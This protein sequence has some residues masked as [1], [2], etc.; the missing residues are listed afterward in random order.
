M[1]ASKYQVLGTSVLILDEIDGHKISEEERR[2]FVVRTADV[3]YGTGSSRVVFLN[4][5]GQMMEELATQGEEGPGLSTLNTIMSNKGISEAFVVRTF[6]ATGM[7]MP[8]SASALFSLG[9]YFYRLNSKKECWIVSGIET[10]RPNIHYVYRESSSAY[11]N[12]NLGLPKPLEDGF[13]GPFLSILTEPA[14]SSENIHSLRVAVPWSGREVPIEFKIM[15]WGWPVFVCF[16]DQQEGDPEDL[17]VIESVFEQPL[18]IQQQFFNTVNSN[19]KSCSELFSIHY[20]RENNVGGRSSLFGENDL[21]SI[22]YARISKKEEIQ[23]RF[24]MGARCRE[25]FFSGVG[26]MA[27]VSAGSELGFIPDMKARVS[28][29]TNLGYGVNSS[30]FVRKTSDSWWMK[31]HPELIWQGRIV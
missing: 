15:D 12:L 23:A 8:F 27:V 13:G 30:V 1:I 18:G 19:I 28:S 31:A 9:D 24:F 6:N 25:P 21:V 14:Q 2:R 20:G 5:M 10:N 17:Y 4:T 11:Y 26:A 16:V 7:E 3:N 22:V 29:I